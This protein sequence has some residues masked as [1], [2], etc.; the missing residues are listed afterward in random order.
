[1]T[2][3]LKL[4]CLVATSLGRTLA[5]W[6]VSVHKPVQT[7]ACCY[8]K[9]WIFSL[10]MRFKLVFFPSN[11]RKISITLFEKL[12]KYACSPV[13]SSVLR[14][15]SFEEMY[16]KK[17]FLFFFI[18][19]STK[20]RS[21]SRAWKIV[22]WLFV[23]AGSTSICTCSPQSLSRDF[24]RILVWNF[25]NWLFFCNTALKPVW[26]SLCLETNPTANSGK[27]SVN[28]KLR[29]ICMQ[30]LDKSKRC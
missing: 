9:K 3:Y 27:I 24:H 6:D 22:K 18:I 25:I 10:P 15:L 30:Y 20:L 23:H 12:L 5:S 16:A 4:K 29:C 11:E 7:K 14:F 19:V 26:I 2:I 8:R 28:P 21:I 17:I 13:S 1:M